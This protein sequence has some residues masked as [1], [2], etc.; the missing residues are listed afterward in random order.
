M[1]VPHHPHLRSPLGLG[2]ATVALLGLVV[3]S[4]VFALGA[5]LD[6]HRVSDDL[7]AGAS[8]FEAAP[9]SG[10][11]HRADTLYMAA[12]LV[13]TAVWLACGVVFLCW[14]YR[15]RLNA[16]V[17]SPDGHRKPRAWVIAGWI[18]PL[19]GFWYPRRI[20]LDIW[21]ASRSGGGRARH[22]L[23]NAWWALWLLATT[24]ETLIADGYDSA[25]TA[26]QFRDAALQGMVVD[27]IDIV[28]AGLAV[29][30]VLRLTR[31]QHQKA[32]ARPIPSRLLAENPLL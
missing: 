27:T 29:L 17:F 12:G 20:V 1:S 23:V 10:P 26:A 24:A 19:A 7:A 14:L 3:L 28:A 5:G 9:M 16:E 8:S 22:G 31:M 15:L 21:D 13:Q 2:Q 32:L 25:R 6:V 18:V 30:L 4:D 11:A